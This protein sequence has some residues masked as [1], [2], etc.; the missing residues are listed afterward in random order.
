MQ[1]LQIETPEH[2]VL[3]F[4]VAGVGSRALAAVIDLAFLGGITFAILF[5]A[6]SLL[7]VGLAS[8]PW[9]AAVIVFLFLLG[10]W[11][12]YIAFEGLR[13]GQTPGKRIVGIRVVSD[14]GHA[15]SFGAAAV[16]N[17]LR[18]ADFLPPPYFTGA[19][20]AALHPRGKRLGDMVAGTVVVWD[21]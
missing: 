4:E 16:R 2:I 6:G 13:Q 3:D 7:G 21:R 9:A 15:V 12:Y 5:I 14:T 19:V 10:W 8:G 20:L 17:L 1:R 18:L 11:L